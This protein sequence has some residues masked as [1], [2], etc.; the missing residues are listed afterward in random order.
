VSWRPAGPSP[1]AVAAVSIA[2]AA[3]AFA[4]YRLTL[5]PGLDFGDTAAFQDTGGRL[6]ITPRQAYPLYFGLSNLVVWSTDA[7]PAYGMNLASAVWGALACGAIAWLASAVT[8][9]AVAGLFT[10]LLFAASY[11]FWSQA[12]IAE[13]YTLHLLMLTASLLALWWWAGDPGSLR[14]LAVFF[15][16]YAAG[17]GNHLMMVL[18]APAAVLFLALTIPGGPPTLMSPRVV[19][20]ALCCAVLGALQYLWNLL[21]V[22]PD[23]IPVTAWPEVL[24]TFW[25]DVTK[26]DW[27]ATMVL[28]VHESALRP[29]AAMYWFDLTQQFGRPGVVLAMLGTAW[30]ARR[31]WRFF[32]LCVAAYVLAM[33]FA[34]TYNVGDAHVFFLPSHLFVV[35]WAGCGVAALLGGLASRLRDRRTRALLAV[36]LLAYP[37]WRLADTWPAV[38]R[39]RDTRPA[40]LV[41]Q[42]TAGLSADRHLLIA[43]LNW[44]LQNGLD[45]HVRHQRPEVDYVHGVGRVLTLP[46]L[47]DEALASGRE[48][49][50]TPQTRH[51]L[52]TAYGPL[53]EFEPDSRV[54]TRSL[55]ERLRPLPQGSVYVLALLRPYSDLPLDTEELQA[56]VAI[57]AGGTATLPP[58]NVYTIMA[59][60][61]GEQPRL[62]HGQ[63]RPFRLRYSDQGLALDIRIESWLPPDTMRRAGFGH[64]I[65]NGRHALTLERGVSFIAFDAEG[66]SHV[67]YAS[68]LFAP[69]PRFL[70]RHAPDPRR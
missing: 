60:R 30:M 17:F 36:L 23:P 27:R 45:Y 29:R 14:R 63:Q 34:Y 39:S 11:T 59:G 40:R 35:L 47:V 44:Q 5:L 7:E 38:D 48:V 52:Q 42:M 24:R 49:V 56:A 53:Y 62:V 68:S 61:V 66:Q 54:E 2:T 19:F 37:A 70:V 69:Q 18:L 55:A 1:A 58:E 3:V 43:D 64:V 6:A 50:V 8:G 51:L 16:V 65:A 41:H 20:T 57:L 46:R 13:V 28:G 33:G 31:N 12:V 9:R 32:A 21:S 26:S 22:H 25:Y 4:V 10:G 67:D 15:L